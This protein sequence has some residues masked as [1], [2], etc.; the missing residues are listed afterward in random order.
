[1]NLKKKKKKIMNLQKSKKTSGGH[2]TLIYTF[3]RIKKYMDLSEISDYEHLKTIL[4]TLCSIGSSISM[5][6]CLERIFVKIPT[7]TS[8]PADFLF[9]GAIHV[10]ASLLNGDHYDVK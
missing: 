4:E 5:Q 1:M 8:P 2:W 7:I 3:E 10:I 9:Y 6:E